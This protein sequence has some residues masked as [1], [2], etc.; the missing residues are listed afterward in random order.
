VPVAWVGQK[1]WDNIVAAC[2]RCNHR[3]GGRTPDDA[4][5][6]FDPASEPNRTGCLHFHVTFRLKSPPDELARYLY[7]NIELDI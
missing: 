4:G 2:F 3:K 7:W 1:R 5:M 6:K